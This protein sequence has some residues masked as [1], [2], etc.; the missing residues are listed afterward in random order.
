MGLIIFESKMYKRWPLGLLILGQGSFGRLAERREAVFSCDHFAQLC[1]RC[2]VE[3]YVVNA[4]LQKDSSQYRRSLLP[5]KN[6]TDI[7]PWKRR[8]H[9]LIGF[10]T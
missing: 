6:V 8:A 3:D 7:L 1:E 5:S 9:D 10:Q 2:G 4:V